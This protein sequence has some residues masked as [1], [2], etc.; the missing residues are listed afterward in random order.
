MSTKIYNGIKFNTSDIY[1]LYDKL[2]I[3]KEE[4]IKLYREMFD[5]RLPDILTYVMKEHYKK[6]GN[7]EDMWNIGDEFIDSLKKDRMILLKNTIQIYPHPK[8]KE[9]Y[10]YFILDNKSEISLLDK[11]W[12]SDYHYQN[13]TDPP[14]DISYEDFEKRSDMWDDLFT[15]SYKIQ[16]SGFEYK[17]YDITEISI[18]MDKVFR[19]TYK[20]LC[21]S[22]PRLLKLERIIEDDKE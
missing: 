12:V 10:G 21:E 13:Q 20:E 17:I 4:S 5:D 9:L 19:K 8:T 15:D 16:D 22:I 3:F 7:L 2:N 1:D 14:E 6:T 18:Y 11:D